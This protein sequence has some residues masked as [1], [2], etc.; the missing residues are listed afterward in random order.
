MKRLTVIMILLAVFLQPVKSQKTYPLDTSHWAINAQ[1]YVLE[2][3]KGYDAIYLQGGTATIKDTKFLNGTIEFDV[4][5]TE[6]Q[7][8]E[9]ISVRWKK[10]DHPLSQADKSTYRPKYTSLMILP[11]HL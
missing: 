8:F 2:N 7:S 9:M 3:Y 1:S 4:Y 11:I 5:L 6:R 10:Q